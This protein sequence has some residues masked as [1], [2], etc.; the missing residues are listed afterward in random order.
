MN[1]YDTANRLSQEIKESSEYKDYKELKEK[2]ESNSEK[3]QKLE[4]F[5]KLRYEVQ[6]ETMKNVNNG[7]ESNSQNNQK[8]IELQE[9]YMELLKDDEFKK[10]FDAEVKFN[11]MITDVNK[12][13][14]EA[15]KD[16]L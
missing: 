10:Y 7:T 6:L 3:K 15:V 8:L 11:V 4:E 16:V 13:I 9:K 14:A 1:V 12:I 5:G 2:I